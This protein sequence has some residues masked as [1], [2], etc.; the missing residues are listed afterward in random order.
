MR[1][2]SYESV[3]GAVGRALDCAQARSFTVREQ[4]QSLLLEALTGEEQQPLSVTLQLAD[5]AELV[6]WSARADA[7]PQNGGTQNTGAL[8]ALLARHEARQATQADERE[9]SVVHAERRE[10]VGAS[11]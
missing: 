2:Y 11:R 10:L 4:E 1:K 5:L 6:D 9:D 8:R 7:T 3:L